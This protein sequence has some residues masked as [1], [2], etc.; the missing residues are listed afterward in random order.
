MAAMRGDAAPT[1]QARLWTQRSALRG[2]VEQ[3]HRHLR[4][5]GASNMF[6]FLEL[7][8]LQSWETSFVAMRA[9][10]RNK[11][12]SGLTALGIII[13]VASVVSMVA[14][15]NGARVRVQSQVARV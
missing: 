7:A 13:G 14:L 2:L 9:L 1:P 4:T 5:S 10:R 15:G 11:L 3:V 12:R 8:L 6:T